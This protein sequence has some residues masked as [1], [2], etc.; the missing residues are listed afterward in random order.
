MSDIKTR[1][2]IIIRVNFNVN[3]R[4]N[5]S[6]RIIFIIIFNITRISRIPSV[7]IRHEKRAL[8]NLVINQNIRK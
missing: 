2:M 7:T 5:N 6:N 1:R 4:S 8:N 3:K